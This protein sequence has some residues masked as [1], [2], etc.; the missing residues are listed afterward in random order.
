MR[1][2]DPPRTADLALSLLANALAANPCR[3]ALAGVLSHALRLNVAFWRSLHETT[4]W[5]THGR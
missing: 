5:I 1:I 3:T 4:G 2:S